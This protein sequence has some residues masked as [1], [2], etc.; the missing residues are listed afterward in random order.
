MFFNDWAEVWK[1]A[2]SGALAYVGLVVL[3]RASGKRT[4]S[5]MNAFDL[6]VTV[7]LGSTL[8]TV[9]LSKEVALVEGLIGLSVLIAL[10]MLVTWLSVHSSVVRR[11]VR[12]EPTL[13]AFR[14]ELL[15]RAM[16]GQ[17]VTESEVLQAVRS[18]GL[19]GLEQVEAVVLESD[20]TLSVVGTADGSQS[21]LRD[22][23]GVTAD[24]G[25]EI[26]ART[27]KSPG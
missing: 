25:G 21:A 14:G 13:L 9:M 3:L 17:R 19:A 6:V 22:V 26:V 11:L 18:N 2:A 4:L 7:A 15:Q 16:T 5:K 8:A 20:G 12:S 24:A 27:G 1:T 10:Q 23:P